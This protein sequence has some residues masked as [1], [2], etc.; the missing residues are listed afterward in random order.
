MRV[1]LAVIDVCT[2]TAWFGRRC[3][4]GLSGNTHWLTGWRMVGVG[5]ENHEAGMPRRSPAAEVAPWWVKL[6][7]TMALPVMGQAVVARA[8][9]AEGTWAQKVAFYRRA[10]ISPAARES[11]LRSVTASEAVRLLAVDV[12]PDGSLLDVAVDAFGP[13]VGLVLLCSTHE[14]FHDDAVRIA[15]R[16]PA[17]QAISVARRW[18]PGRSMPTSVHVALVEAMLADVPSRQVAEGPDEEEN[19]RAQEAQF[20]REEEWENHLWEILEPLP[21]VW[22]P[23]AERRDR[24]GRHVQWVLLAKADDLPDDVLRACVPAV[25]HAW[26]GAC[27]SPSLTAQIRLCAMQ[28]YA[29]RFPRLRE[30][31]QGQID[32]TVSDV[33]AT[34]WSVVPEFWWATDW[35][36]VDALAEVCSAPRVL[37][38][39]VDALVD[40]ALPEAAPDS[41]E[42]EQWLA[43][44]AK[45]AAGLA[46]NGKT[47]D[48]SVRRLLPLLDSA[49]IHVIASRRGQS[50]RNA[51][52]AELARRS[53]AVGGGSS[54][55]A[56]RRPT[57]ACAVPSDRSLAAQADQSAALRG[58]LGLLDGPPDERA[59]AL[60]AMLASDYVDD[61]LLRELPA[62]A[63][64]SSERHAERVAS[65]IAAA[66][67]DDERRWNAWEELVTSAGAETFGELLRD[68][69]IAS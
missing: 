35:D 38:R 42:R 58:C 26:W 54:A 25:T 4:R 22:R 2:A 13:S 60:A 32:R 31:A 62:A 28:K 65:I 37:A 24:A 68:L 14:E 53:N 33:L 23:L 44:R 49:A 48:A 3:E 40:A 56:K 66:C 47:P 59:L 50:L 63:V 55:G 16:L 64:L 34:G 39:S 15:T 8:L 18:P 21:Q 57:S 7:D 12:R 29:A 52:A 43:R 36:P 5:A 69:D 20:H 45:A 6:A 67:G 30:I 17:D 9:A 1:N 51:C 61:R 19:R 27:R 10:D 41:R 11:M 46:L